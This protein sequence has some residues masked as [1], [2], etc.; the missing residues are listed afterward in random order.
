MTTQ[1]I[2]AVDVKDRILKDHVNRTLNE[3]LLELSLSHKNKLIASGAGTLSV[4]TDGRLLIEAIADSIPIDFDF[5]SL[6]GSVIGEDDFCQIKAK[7]G[8]DFFLNAEKLYPKK[9]SRHLHESDRILFSPATVT[10]SS[11]AM[12]NPTARLDA[13][14]TPFEE[15]IFNRHCHNGE[16]NPIFGD[17]KGGAWLGIE[18]P[19]VAIGLRKEAKTE[20]HLVVGSR[21]ADNVGVE[22]YAVAFLNAFSFLVGRQI[23]IIAYAQTDRKGSKLVLVKHDPPP[24]QFYEPVP[25]GEEKGAVKLL[26]SGVDFFSRDDCS[27]ILTALH[28]C[29]ESRKVTFPASYLLVCCAVE[30]LADYILRKAENTLKELRGDLIS[31]V[32]ERQ[33]AENKTYLDKVKKAIDRVDFFNDGEK[34][35]RA[36]KVLKIEITKSE[37]A[38]WH[39]LRHRLAHGNFDLDVQSLEVIQTELNRAACVANIVNKFV[40]ALIHYEGPYRDYSTLGY[41]TRNFPSATDGLPIS[42][43]SRDSP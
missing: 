15:Y 33:N 19:E 31:F 43:A 2:S 35:Y 40:L 5:R 37:L 10:L 41:P 42:P 12:S 29:R 24:K 6:E 30:G 16:T 26:E 17:C 4:D 38:A 23:R 9:I 13:L 25:E 3:P 36:S 8:N 14:I 27:P 21:P 32:D 28:V 7:V 39:K 22:K 20:F 18:K 11:D 34:I 1:A